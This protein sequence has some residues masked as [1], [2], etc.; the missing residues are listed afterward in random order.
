[1]S[2]SIK[3]QPTLDDGICGQ[4]SDGQVMTRRNQ[5]VVFCHDMDRQI[6]APV[7]TCSRFHHKGE[8][9]KWDM[10]QIAWTLKTD[11]SGRVMGFA[12]PK[13]EDD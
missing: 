3:V 13:K 2:H 6:H 1:M 8:P 5:T 4:C 7:D 9:T 10:E 11:R 12:A